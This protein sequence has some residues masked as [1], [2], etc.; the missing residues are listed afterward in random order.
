MLTLGNKRQG[1]A[2]A[3]LVD[4]DVRYLPPGLPYWCPRQYKHHSEGTYQVSPVGTTPCQSTAQHG[5][6]FLDG[7]AE[8][9]L[10]ARMHSS[11]PKRNAI[12][13]NRHEHSFT[14]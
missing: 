1:R 3:T 6:Y 4:H 5:S 2:Q 10:P 11:C 9:S 8:S 13:E 12:V 7:V 14:K